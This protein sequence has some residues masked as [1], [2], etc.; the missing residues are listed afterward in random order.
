[1]SQREVAPHL[2]LS[3]GA[4][5]ARWALVCATVAVF[6]FN[7]WSISFGPF[8]LFYDFPTL[9]M[10]MIVTGDYP[11]FLLSIWEISFF[12]F[13]GVLYVVD[14]LYLVANPTCPPPTGTCLNPPVAGPFT[15]LTL[16]GAAVAFSWVFWSLRNRDSAMRQLTAEPPRM[17]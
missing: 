16:F 13:V 1:M 9:V 6:V 2:V 17:P 4:T 5:R 3:K 10:L 7:L 12:A 11:K 14:E 8:F 15:P